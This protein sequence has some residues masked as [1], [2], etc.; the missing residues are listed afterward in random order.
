MAELNL[1]EE[2][3][4]GLWDYWQEHP[5]AYRQIRREQIER[6]KDAH[7]NVIKKYRKA[8]DYYVEQMKI[9]ESLNNFLQSMRGG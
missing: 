1:R 5:E 4:R 7:G 9:F 3:T 8:H 6:C 2:V